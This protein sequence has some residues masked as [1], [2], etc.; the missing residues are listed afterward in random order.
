MAYKSKEP[1]GLTVEDTAEELQ[2]NVQTVRKWLRQGRL[3]GRKIGREWRI[4]RQE[5]EDY[6]RGK[7]LGK[8]AQKI[9]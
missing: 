8:E 3:P 4:S 1:M 6:L 7:Y 2:L 9:E 5:L